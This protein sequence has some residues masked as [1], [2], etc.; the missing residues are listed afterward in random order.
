MKKG[1]EKDFPGSKIY[2]TEADSSSQGF[3]NINPI[4]FD[5][6]IKLWLLL[7]EHTILST[8]HMLHSFLTFDWLRRNAKVVA[9][10]SEEDAILT[11]LREDRDGFKSFVVED[12]EKEDYPSLHKNYKKDLI[13]RA[14]ILSDILHSAICWCP[15]GESQ[16]FRDTIVKDLKDNKSPLRKRMVCVANTAI[17]NLAKDIS[18][19]DFLNRETL[20]QLIN[21]HCPQRK[22][23][24]LRYGDIFYYLSGALYKD[25]FPVFHPE[26]AELCKEK[27]SYEVYSCHKDF[28]KQDD[29]WKDV[30]NAWGIT[31]DAL[32]KLPLSEVVSIRKDSLG[33]QLRETWGSLMK[34]A[35]SSQ[36]NEKDIVAF[37]KAKGKLIELFKQ[38][39]I[40]QKEQFHKLQ[41]YRG[42]I[43]VGS[44]VTGVLSTVISSF[45]GLPPVSSAASGVLGFLAGKPVLDFVEKKSPKA[46]LII[47]SSK[48]QHKMNK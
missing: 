4:E 13:H 41:K 19:Y 17:E 34:Q 39:V 12:P 33:I 25:A 23:L 7:S 30:I 9:E 48:I 11:S 10:L 31:Y 2:F 29:I 38:E 14:D 3:Y 36:V 6:K 26:A 22:K 18:S 21:N 35:R 47:L 20:S 1:F 45:I 5:I 24:L 44:W 28:N 15:T 16:L 8:G 32:K 27:V 40:T 46:E 37:Q 43:E 42:M